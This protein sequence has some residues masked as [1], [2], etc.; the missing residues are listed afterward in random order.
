MSSDAKEVLRHFKQLL[1][2]HWHEIADLFRG[3]LSELDQDNA[4][5]LGA[6][7]A[8]YSLLSLAPLLV[9]IVA[10]GALVFGREPAQ[11]QL[12][13]QF[14]GLVGRQEAIAIQALIQQA[15]KPGT[16]VLATLLGVLTL[17]WGASAVTVELREALNTIWHVS[18]KSA[19]RYSGLIRL[20]T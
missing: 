2:L 11:G 9:V 12:A 4:P 13:W 16:G 19:K 8:F 10:V 3:T 7:L 14:Q 15:Y 1:H 18:D 17:L 20:A 6:A 5:R